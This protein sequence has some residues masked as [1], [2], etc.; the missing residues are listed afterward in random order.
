MASNGAN[1]FALSCKVIISCSVTSNHTVTL[2]LRCPCKI[3]CASK[4]SVFSVLIC[5]LQNRL[6]LCLFPFYCIPIGK[7][8]IALTALITDIVDGQ[9]KVYVF[10]A[11]TLDYTPIR[12]S[13]A[14]LLSM[15]ADIP[16]FIS[17]TLMRQQSV[18]YTGKKTGVT[19]PINAISIP[20]L[21][22]SLK[23]AIDSENYEMASKLRDE[24]NKRK[25]DS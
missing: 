14:V 13:D 1:C 7:E 21:E 4:H 12:A 8:I 17:E 18:E 11:D 3:I 10:N 9:Y 15:V 24:I 25:K 16:I 6:F 2:T 20:M 23:K 19:V 5:Y 22:E